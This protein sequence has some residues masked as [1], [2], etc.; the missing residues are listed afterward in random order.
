MARNSESSPQRCVA[1]CRQTLIH[2]R[3]VKS[4]EGGGGRK[5]VGARIHPQPQRDSNHFNVKI[6]FP[7][8]SKL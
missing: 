1:C 2:S 4:P 7:L 6:Y 5:A 8:Q 3:D